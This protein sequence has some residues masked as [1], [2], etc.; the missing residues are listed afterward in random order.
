MTT[1]YL[2]KDRRTVEGGLING[3][4]HIVPPDGLSLCGRRLR[5]FIVS[6]VNRPDEMVLCPACLAHE[7]KATRKAWKA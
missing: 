2:R 1:L 6:A 3:P 7:R 4:T 5:G